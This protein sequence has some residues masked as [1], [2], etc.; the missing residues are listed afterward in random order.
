[1]TVAQKEGTVAFEL[2]K[3]MSKLNDCKSVAEVLA[4]VKSCIPEKKAKE[5]KVLELVN[6]IER[7]RDLFSAYSTVTNFVLKSDNLGV[8][9]KGK[10]RVGRATTKQRRSTR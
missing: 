10:V 9:D 1:M 8:V 3:N 5:A 4:F 2:S 6:H 7:S